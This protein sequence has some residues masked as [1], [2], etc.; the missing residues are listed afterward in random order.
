MVYSSFFDEYFS[1][2]PLIN[3]VTNI[4]KEDVTPIL[5]RR[6][7]VTRNRN[8][9]GDEL[10]L[11]SFYPHKLVVRLLADDSIIGIIFL[12]LLTS[13]FDIDIHHGKCCTYSIRIGNN[14]ESIDLKTSSEKDFISWK[15]E[16][17]KYCVQDQFYSKYKVEQT[18]GQGAHGV[19]YLVEHMVTKEKFA[20]K[21]IDKPAL[22]KQSTS[23]RAMVFNEIRTMI[24]LD[25]E[26]ILKLH[27][28][29]ETSTK[30]ILILEYVEGGNLFTSL[31]KPLGKIPLKVVTTIIKQL[32][33][34]LEYLADQGI[35]HRDIKPENVLVQKSED[36]SFVVKLADFGLSCR[37][38][39]IDNNIAGT[40]GYIA[41]ELLQ[42]N[43]KN[44][45]E[46]SSI[47]TKNDMFSL[48]CI[49]YEL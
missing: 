18:L 9:K 41:P 36:H 1:E 27:E 46:K 4:E 20:A 11:V 15:D 6:F 34:A 24:K 47:S 5:Q 29:H 26:H 30:I 39:E 2:S 49:F 44:D 14:K 13:R 21:A 28:I 42:K 38:N 16:L 31:I 43:S 10:W 45:E 25:H 3:P 32:L 40:P 33:S 17:S 37:E 7:R 12:D 22:M 35:V 8:I 48:G 23:R 19:V